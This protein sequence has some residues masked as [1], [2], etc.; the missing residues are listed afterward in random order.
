[1]WYGGVSM[2]RRVVIGI[3]SVTIAYCFVVGTATFTRAGPLVSF[4]VAMAALP[5]TALAFAGAIS[6][7]V[8]DRWLARQGQPLPAPTV[9]RKPIRWVLWTYS[10]VAMGLFVLGPLRPSTDQPMRYHAGRY[11]L[12]YRGPV[13]SHDTWLHAYAQWERPLVAIPS[14]MAVMAILMVSESPTIR[15]RDG[16]M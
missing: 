8:N 12:G 5:G 3:S 14:I 6:I 2:V 11:V 7:R 16:R 9:L 15:E 1:M 13:V 10:Y 4:T